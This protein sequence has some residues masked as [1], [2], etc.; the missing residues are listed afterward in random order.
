MRLGKHRRVDGDAATPITR[1][2]GPYL[3]DDEPRY[4][5]GG[6]VKFAFIGEP[7]SAKMGLVHR[8]DLLKHLRPAQQIRAS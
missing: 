5:A 7:S 2:E 4:V 6:R 3:K 8:A 1:I